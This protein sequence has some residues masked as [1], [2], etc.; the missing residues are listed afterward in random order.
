MDIPGWARQ[1]GFDVRFDWGP[2]GVEAIACSYVV[3]VDVLRFTTAVEAAVSRGARVY[4]YRWNDDSAQDFADRLDARLADGSDPAGLSLSPVRLLQLQPDDRV[5]LPSPNGSTCAAIASECGAIVV[6]ACLRNARAVAGWLNG[7]SASVAVVACGER[8]P[9]GSLRPSLED[10]LGAGAVIAGLK[11]SRSPEASV[12]AIVWSDLE[13]RAN[14]LVHACSSARELEDR[15]RRD[16]LAYASD[17]HASSTVP[18]LGHG[19]FSD[20]ASL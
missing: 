16:D 4:P 18:V 10:Y 19:A 14:D 13:P 11:G 6:A 3:I 1:E 2:A 5:V 7:V 15:G 17:I 9:D 12:A 8:W 20:A